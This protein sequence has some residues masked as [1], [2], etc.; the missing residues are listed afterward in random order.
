MKRLLFHRRG[1]PDIRSG[2][3]SGAGSAKP[4][5]I[6]AGSDPDP[7]PDRIGSYDECQFRIQTI[8][9]GTKREIELLSMF[10]LKN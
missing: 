8:W 2:R 5:P 7:A 9:L 4:D 3:I 6:R 1:A 10:S